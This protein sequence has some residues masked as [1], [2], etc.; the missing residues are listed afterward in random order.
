VTHNHYTPE[1]L[2][3]LD[4][5]IE[6]AQKRH[7]RAMYAMGSDESSHESW[8]DNPAF[9]QAKQDE[10]MARTHLANLRV[11]RRNAIV[12]KRDTA[13]TVVEVGS[14]VRV[15]IDGE[16]EPMTIHMAGHFFGSRES[17]DGMFMMSTTSPIGKALMGK[18][19]GE[20]I[21][22]TSGTDKALGATVLELV[23]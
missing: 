3:A 7:A 23:N 6:V 8:H 14:T 4:A 9:E 1:A 18:T 13:S 11:L 19:E 17:E 21:T 16:D 5:N 22:Y 2:V 15:L 20:H 12:V 10:D